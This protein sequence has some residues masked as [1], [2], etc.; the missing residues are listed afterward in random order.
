[1]LYCLLCERSLT[2]R[3]PN[4]AYDRIWTNF[5]DELWEDLSVSPTVK[6]IA[7]NAYQIPFDALKT[8][9][10][11]VNETELSIGCS[12][13]RYLSTNQFYLYLHFAEIEELQPDELRAFDIY[14]NEERWFEYAVPKYL[15]SKTIYSINPINETSIDVRLQ[16]AENSTLP[17]L[18]NA[19][20]VYVVL[21]LPEA[22]TYEQDGTPFLYLNFLCHCQSFLFANH[23]FSFL[24]LMLSRK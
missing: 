19:F 2:C 20:E 4:D 15:R 16:K 21:E 23:L 24:Q 8:A 22:E 3:Y 1:M 9:V 18:L 7:Q 5:P 10:T 13:S 12:T 11:Q 17:P 14:I 6:S